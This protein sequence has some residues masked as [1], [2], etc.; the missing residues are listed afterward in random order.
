MATVAE[1]RKAA[2]DLPNGTAVSV[3]G[4]GHI[5]PLLQNAPA[6]AELIIGFWAGRGKVLYSGD[7]AG[8]A[9]QLGSLDIP[10]P[11]TVQVGCPSDRGQCEGSCC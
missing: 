4:A 8:A 10:D 2:G 7:C 11:M 3:P 5:T 9:A 1:A 6:L